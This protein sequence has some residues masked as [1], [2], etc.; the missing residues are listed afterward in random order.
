MA[1]LTLSG[2]ARHCGV[3]CRNKGR[4]IMWHPTQGAVLCERVLHKRKMAPK[5]H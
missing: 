5:R 1:A 4:R 2:G 3:E